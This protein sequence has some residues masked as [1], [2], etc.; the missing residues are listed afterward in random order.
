V[1]Q[2]RGRPRGAGEIADDIARLRASGLVGED[3]ASPPGVDPELPGVRLQTSRP[4]GAPIHLTL[5]GA[6]LPSWALVLEASDEVVPGPRLDAAFAVGLAD[7]DDDELDEWTL[8]PA[9][10]RRE[11]VAALEARAIPVDDGIRS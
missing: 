10:L 1:W 5:R 7:P 6:A 11:L 9:A 2:R 4:L 8:D 3:D